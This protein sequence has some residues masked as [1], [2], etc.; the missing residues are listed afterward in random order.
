M[1]FKCIFCKKDFES[2]SNNYEHALLNCLGGRFKT[3]KV[4]CSK[5]NNDFGIGIDDE[6]A[7]SVQD[8]RCVGAL[9]S[10]DKKLPPPIK[11]IKLMNGMI[12]DLLAGMV[13]YSREVKYEREKL[14]NGNLEVRFGA[15]SF[16]QLSKLLPHFAKGSGL[17]FEQLISIIRNIEIKIQQIA[18]NEHIPLKFAF[19]G[20]HPTRSMAKSLTVLWCHHYG[21]DEFIQNNFEDTVR[22]ITDEKFASENKEFAKIDS[23]PIHL[24][25]DIILKKTFGNH[26]NLM[27]VHADQDGNLNGVFRMYN[28]VNWIFNLRGKTHNKNSNIILISNPFSPEIW[29]IFQNVTLPFDSSWF[30]QSQY[31]LTDI[32]RNTACLIEACMKS[33]QAQSLE[34]LVEESIRDYFPNDG[35]VIQAEHVNLL[36][37]NVAEEF[38]AREYGLNREKIISGEKAV[39][40]IE[41]IMRKNKK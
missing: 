12:I 18:I 17:T 22:F 29:E 15:G 5:C 23:R 26:Y 39:S 35:D 10:G 6:M 16:E 25:E 13:P 24:P 7:K 19:G 14:A 37:Q 8:F 32:Q 1:I 9:R 21:N 41:S 27:I 3:S 20:L 36:S 11:D 40:I 30:H 31:V 4:D 28:V 2:E 34:K 38:V 33:N